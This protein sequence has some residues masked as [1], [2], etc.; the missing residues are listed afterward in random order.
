MDFHDSLLVFNYL[1]YEKR[2]ESS[3]YWYYILLCS[4]ILI[5]CLF[6]MFPLFTIISEIGNT[7]CHR[8]VDTIGR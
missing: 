2:R 6:S 4:F 3:S 8:M 1:D 5:L 7:F